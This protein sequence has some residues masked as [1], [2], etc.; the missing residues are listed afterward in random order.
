MTIVIIDPSWPSSPTR[1][2]VTGS[3]V[4]KLFVNTTTVSTWCIR[5]SRGTA[6][7]FV[8]LNCRLYI[9]KITHR[10][11][12]WY[13]YIELCV[14]MYHGKLLNYFFTNRVV[15]ICILK[16]QYFMSWCAHRLLMNPGNLFTKWG[17]NKLVD[18]WLSHFQTHLLQWKSLKIKKR[19]I[20]MYSWLLNWQ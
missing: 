6:K 4:V 11:M 20:V 9:K 5:N 13:R 8:V 1:V 14:W 19:L 3:Q 2:S 15:Y 18:I 7:F 10:D 17:L 16:C 12:L